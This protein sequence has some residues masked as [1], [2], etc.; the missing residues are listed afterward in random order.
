MADALR[1]REHRILDQGAER[2][3][4][5]ER[6]RRNLLDAMTSRKLKAL[7]VFERYNRRLGL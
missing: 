7:F 1:Q 5:D 6:R 4:D 3:P 2:D